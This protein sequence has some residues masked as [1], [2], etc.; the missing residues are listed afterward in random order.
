MQCFN[1]KCRLM[2]KIIAHLQIGD[3][4]YVKRI[5]SRSIRVSVSARKGVRVSLPFWV[6]YGKAQQFVE[7]NLDKILRVLERQMQ[8]GAA[9]KGLYSAEELLDIRRR[10]KEYLPARLAYW[11]GIL[12]EKI[13]SSASGSA[14]S[15][16]PFDY[17]RVFIKNNRTN[18]GSCSAK[19]N[20]NLNMHLVDLPGELSDFVIIHELCHLVHRNHGK[21]FHKLVNSF[22]GGREKELSASLRKYSHL[23]Q[24]IP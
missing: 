12:N 21:E 10:A 11:A 24:R 23:L 16:R 7:T 1:N 17:S 14:S 13:S 4:L 20:I 3:I 22:C 6:T 2:Q 19:R 5:G 15:D 18:W 9:Q 8:S